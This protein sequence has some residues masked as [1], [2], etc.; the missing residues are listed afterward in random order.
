MVCYSSSGKLIPWSSISRLY[1]PESYV[2]IGMCQIQGH[3]ERVSR[4]RAAPVGKSRTNGLRPIYSPKVAQT[5][6]CKDEDPILRSR[7][8]SV[9]RWSSF[10]SWLPL[11]VT[12]QPGA[13]LF[14]SLC[15]SFSLCKKGTLSVPTC[16]VVVRIMQCSA[17]IKWPK[18]KGH[19]E[20][21]IVK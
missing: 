3:I 11:S 1:R 21:R 17:L 2:S 18:S 16:S 13:S 4:Y 12:V 20:L 19:H 7:A 8:Q 6:I 5:L 9:D 10:R 15:L 14:S